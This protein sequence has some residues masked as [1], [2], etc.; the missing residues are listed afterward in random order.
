MPKVF[1]KT[2]EEIETKIKN[3]GY[4][5]ACDAHRA[6]YHT[7]FNETIRRRLHKIIDVHFEAKQGTKK[8]REVGKR[9]TGDVNGNGESLMVTMLRIIKHVEVRN[10][11]MRLHAKAIDEG[12]TLPDL[13]AD[14]KSILQVLP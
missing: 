10:L 11:V 12:K 3:D 14:M 4:A 6:L 7:A 9:G 2:P 13:H 1:R 5:R 8:Q